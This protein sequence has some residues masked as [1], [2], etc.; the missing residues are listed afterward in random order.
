MLREMTGGA[1]SETG[2][3]TDLKMLIFVLHRYTDDAKSS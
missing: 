1:H 3:I 2:N